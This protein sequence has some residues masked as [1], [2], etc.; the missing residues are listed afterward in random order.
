M[1]AYQAAIVFFI[2]TGYCKSV[3]RI[4]PPAAFTAVTYNAHYMNNG[5]S[6]F[7]RTLAPLQAD[8]IAMQEVLVK[9]GYVTTRTIAN[10]IGY[11]QINSSPY[12]SYGNNHWVLSFLTRYQVLFADETKIGDYRRALRV[13]LNVNGHRVQFVTLHLTPYS[14]KHPLLSSNE[15]RSDSR[16]KEIHDLLTWIGRPKDPVVL[17]GDFN[18]LR[19]IPGLLGLNEYAMVTS[20]GFRDADGGLL[21]TNHDTFP[22]DEYAKKKARE[23]IPGFLVPSGITLDYV[24]ISRGIKIISTSVIKSKASDHWPLLAR[25]QVGD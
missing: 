16:K 21:P 1:K 4:N 7:T 9:D 22:V 24:F 12:V 10:S 3:P 6:G 2:L 18:M 19:G 14:E 20:A 15:R 17:L 8:V 13:I 5:L 25:L 23:K 11:K